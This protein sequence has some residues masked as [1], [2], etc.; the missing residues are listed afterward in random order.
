MMKKIGLK[1]V[2][3][4]IEREYY[5]YCLEAIKKYSR[6][7]LKIFGVFYSIGLFVALLQIIF[8]QNSSPFLYSCMIC[9][10]F[11]FVLYFAQKYNKVLRANFGSIYGC[12]ICIT[13]AESCFQYS[14]STVVMIQQYTSY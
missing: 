7:A 10:T 1:F 14:A 2:N 12:F 9:L 4:E 3:V 11:I 8:F 5:E 13:V 6:V